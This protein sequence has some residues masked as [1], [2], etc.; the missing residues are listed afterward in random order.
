M[1][2]TFD[3]ANREKTLAERG[4]DFADAVL[5]F[6]GVTVIV[7]DTRKSYGETRIICKESVRVI[8]RCEAK[9]TLVDER[10]KARKNRRRIRWNTLRIFSGRERRRCQQIVCRS[11]M[12]LFGQTPNHADRLHTPA[13]QALHGCR[14]CH[15]HA[16]FEANGHIRFVHLGLFGKSRFQQQRTIL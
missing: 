12:A 4:L 9:E 16:P 8:L 2:V 13:H 3:S 15:V 10:R 6:S 11:R 1:R 7:E 5:V 14:I